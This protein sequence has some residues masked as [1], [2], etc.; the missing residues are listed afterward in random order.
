MVPR[1]TIAL[2]LVTFVRI[3]QTEEHMSIESGLAAITTVLIILD[4]V[5]DGSLTR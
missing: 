4:P 2:L 3:H 5:P 1:P